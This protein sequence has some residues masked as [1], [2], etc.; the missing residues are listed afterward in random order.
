MQS[1]GS[2]FLASMFIV[3]SGI[4]LVSQSDNTFA[5]NL[6]VATTIA[7]AAIVIASFIFTKMYVKIRK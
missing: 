6:L 1:S 2:R 3:G 4:A 7:A 5:L